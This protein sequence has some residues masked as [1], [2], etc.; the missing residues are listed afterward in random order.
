[1]LNNVKILQSTP[2]NLAE[3]IEENLSLIKNAS[4]ISTIS[5]F[6]LVYPKQESKVVSIMVN[7]GKE[8]ILTSRDYPHLGFYQREKVLIIAGNFLVSALPLIYQ[9]KS[10]FSP[11]NPGIYW[12]EN[13]AVFLEADFLP[14]SCGVYHEVAP[15]IQIARGCA[16]I[17]DCGYA[18]ALFKMGSTFKLFQIEG[19]RVNELPLQF[20]LNSTAFIQLQRQLYD[21]KNRYSKDLCGTIPVFNFSRY[22][23]ADCDPFRFYK[24]DFM[25]LKLLRY[26][27]LIF[28][29]KSLASGTI[30]EQKNLFDIKKNLFRK[31]YLVS[32]RYDLLKSPL[33]FSQEIPIRYLTSSFI[34]LKVELRERDGEIEGIK[35]QRRR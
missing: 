19:T 24:V 23:F 12:V 25:K 8:K 9:I 6:G 21:I 3:K 22:D 4:V 13:E 11:L 27:G 33:A 5:P 20:N 30:C 28:A 2:E 35:R 1:M 26:I 15:L 7:F 10:F 16:V 18:L 34:I 31:L 17:H 14:G 29:P 32:R